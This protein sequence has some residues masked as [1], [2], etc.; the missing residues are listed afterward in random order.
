VSKE[1]FGQ[2]S[3]LAFELLDADRD[4]FLSRAE[5]EAGILNENI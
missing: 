2:V 1:E 4:G 3:R 5:W